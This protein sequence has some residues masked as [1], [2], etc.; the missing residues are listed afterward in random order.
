MIAATASMISG[1]SR[2]RVGSPPASETIMVPIRD[3]LAAI[4]PNADGVS[5]ASR[6]NGSFQ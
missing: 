6:S 1:R 3:S 4:S 5:W 2:R